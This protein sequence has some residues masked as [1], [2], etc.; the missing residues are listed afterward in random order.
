MKSAV[1]LCFQSVIHAYWA[2]LSH[3]HLFHVRGVRLRANSLM[4]KYIVMHILLWCLIVFHRAK[5]P[6]KVH[7]WAGISLRGAT[8][9]CIFDGIMDAELYIQILDRTLVP[10]LREAFP[11]GHW[12][13]H[14]R[15]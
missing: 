7:V 9:A 3:S 6:T 5:H 2:H 14:A 13:I 8:G 15:Q 10:F 4:Q 11:E 12:F 1:V